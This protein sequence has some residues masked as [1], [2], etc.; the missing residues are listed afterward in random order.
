MSYGGNVTA[1]AAAAHFAAGAPALARLRHLSL[2]W[3]QSSTT[4]AH[5]P[6]LG[7]LTA[8]T[9]LSFSSQGQAG[10]VKEEDLVLA[11]QPVSR[12]LREL[13]LRRLPLVTPR[14]VVMLQGVLPF[15]QGCVFEACGCLTRPTA[16]LKRSSCSC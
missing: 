5:L 11:L 4:S 6:D 10:C 1:E 15:L 12:T 13:R 8:L 9:S 14:T 7:A 2:T 3:P 16:A